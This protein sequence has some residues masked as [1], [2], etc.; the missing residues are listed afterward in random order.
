MLDHLLR[1]GIPANR[2]AE[3]LGDSAEEA[4]GGGAETDAEDIAGQLVGVGADYVDRILPVLF[5]LNWPIR[6]WHTASS[7]QAR[8]PACVGNSVYES[9]VV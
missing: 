5:I 8:V 9:D 2:A 1:G 7:S 4:D 3:T 6:D